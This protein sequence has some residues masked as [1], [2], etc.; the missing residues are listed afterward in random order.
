MTQA[1][2]E[3]S[4]TLTITSCWC[5]IRLAVP[6]NLYRYAR[7]HEGKSIY[8]PLGHTF[9]FNH[10]TEQENRELKDRLERA[11]DLAQDLR[12]QRDRE[13]FRVRALKGVVTRTKHRAANGV[14]PFC[15]RTFSNVQRH[16]EHKHALML[17]STALALVES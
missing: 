3:F 14:C 6:T 16:V 7:N 2:M 8:C 13:R 10:T 1:L 17:Q 15:T 12:E 11:R 4:D 9:V 5:G